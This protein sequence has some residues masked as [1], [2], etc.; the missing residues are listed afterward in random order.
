MREGGTTKALF[1]QLPASRE[2]VVP[3]P[4]LPGVNARI[5]VTAVV[6]EGA[7]GVAALQAD[8]WTDRG[9]QFGKRKERIEVTMEGVSGL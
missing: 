4:F 3:L 1:S 6:L 8:T 9:N 7:A 5:R 2:S